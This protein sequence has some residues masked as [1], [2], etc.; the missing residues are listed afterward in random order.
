MNSNVSQA[1]SPS[2]RIGK[3]IP[4][5]EGC[6]ES[7]LLLRSGAGMGTTIIGVEANVAATGCQGSGFCFPGS[8]AR[9]GDLPVRF[10]GSGGAG[11]LNDAMAVKANCDVCACWADCK[12]VMEDRIAGRP[13]AGWQNLQ[14]LVMHLRVEEYEARWRAR[15]CPRV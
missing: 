1:G 8:D 12:R 9:T 15:R 14:L 3:S 11:P 10:S 7:E 13:L 2:C 5:V 4:R 6:G